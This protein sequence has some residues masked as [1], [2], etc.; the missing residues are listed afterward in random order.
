MALFDEIPLLNGKG[1]D[2][3]HMFSIIFAIV[4]GLVTLILLV[5]LGLLRQLARLL[6]HYQK[7][8]YSQISKNEPLL[9]LDDSV[10]TT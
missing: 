3:S 1:F 2:Y 9:R 6:S 5:A 7:K 4:L 10:K 8:S